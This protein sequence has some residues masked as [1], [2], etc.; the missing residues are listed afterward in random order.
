M[1]NLLMWC[2]LPAG[3]VA[4]RVVVYD[5][6]CLRK[7]EK[8]APAT[9]EVHRR[10]WK[11]QATGGPY[12]CAVESYRFDRFALSVLV[13]IWRQVHL[14]DT[15]CHD[16]LLA[17][18]VSTTHCVGR[19][20]SNSATLACS[21]IHMSQ[22]SLSATEFPAETNT[23]GSG[24]RCPRDAKVCRCRKDAGVGAVRGPTCWPRIFHWSSPGACFPFLRHARTEAALW[25]SPWTRSR[26]R[27][28][29]QRCRTV[30]ALRISCRSFA[31]KSA[32][33][34]IICVVSQEFFG[35]TVCR[36]SGS[37]LQLLLKDPR[38][39][40]HSTSKHWKVAVFGRLSSPKWPRS[41]QMR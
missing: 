5:P 2:T 4:T 26:E 37:M 12:W 32:R 11:T 22:L 36:V 40:L 10:D 3:R 13:S 34:H 14:A 6:P 24:L 16:G 28:A 7:T 38:V 31:P 25:R 21:A 20:S 8:S 29:S 30:V 27:G 41:K 23:S 1:R 19:C 35:G 15:P 17:E 9:V 18:F 33:S 39:L